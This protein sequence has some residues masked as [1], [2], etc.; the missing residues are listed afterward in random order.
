MFTTSLFQAI[1]I[2]ALIVGLIFAVTQNAVAQS[3]SNGSNF[4]NIPSSTRTCGGNFNEVPPFKISP[5]LSRRNHPFDDGR[6]FAQY[7][8]IGLSRSIKGSGVS[9]F[10]SFI[11]SAASANAFTKLSFSGTSISPVY[12]QSNILRL[13][14]MYI[15]FADQKGLLTP[16]ERKLMIAWGN[17]M[18]AAQK[19]SKG[20]KSADSRAASGVALISWGAVTGNKGTFS[21]GVRQYKEALPFILRNVGKLKRQ[22][23]LRSVPVSALSLEDEYNLTLAHVIE[24]AAILRNLGIDVYGQKVNGKTIH[25]AVAWWSG[26]ISNPPTGFKGYS[27]KSHN[28]HLGWIPIYLSQYPNRPSSGALRKVA[29]KVSKGRRPMFAGIS[30]GGATD[31]FWGFR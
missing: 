8:G 4:W 27:R 28:F 6:L 31:C 18:V 7:F 17:K 24:G 10:K 12:V 23:A 16:A 3:K 19:S 15:S 13:I 25:D 9:Q 14:A 21:K 30:L 11:L 22:S 29:V 2:S 26:V 20:N 5:V 1:K